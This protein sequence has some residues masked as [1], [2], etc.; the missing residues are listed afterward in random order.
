MST[1]TIGMGEGHVGQQPGRAMERRI[2]ELS[3]GYQEFKVVAAGVTLGLFE[4]LREG[5]R[6]AAAMAEE[7]GLAERGLEIL[8]DALTALG[9]LRKEGARYSLPPEARDLLLAEGRASMVNALTHRNRGFSTWAG[10]EAAVR[11]GGGIPD[12]ERA[13]LRD[14]AANRAFILAMAEVSRGRVDRVLDALPLDGVRLMVDLGGGPG[15]Y[16]CGLVHR[17]PEAR[18]LVVDLPLTVEV[19]EEYVATQGLTDRVGTRVCDFYGA[20]ALDLG[21]PADLVLISQVLH[22]EGP[23]QNRALLAKVRDATAAGGWV[24]IAENLVDESR[25]SPMTA[26]MFAVNMLVST[27]RGRTYTLGEVTGWLSAAG[28]RPA[29]HT[30]I[31]DRTCVVLGQAR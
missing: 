11:R 31:D 25:T 18:A 15:H 22:A 3:R 6:G 7:L 21:E 5:P 29:G 8:A 12:R 16:A 10:L 13:T 17:L 27:E 20:D 30:R 14:R 26:A 19:A 1:G 28:F 9:Y 2:A 24:A 4:A 23:E